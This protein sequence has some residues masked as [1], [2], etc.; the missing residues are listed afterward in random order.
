MRYLSGDGLGEW[1]SSNLMPTAALARL[2]MPDDWANLTRGART[3]R[4]HRA[5]A[6]ALIASRV[7]TV[8]AAGVVPPR[9]RLPVAGKEDARTQS[10]PD[11]TPK[12]GP[13]SRLSTR[14]AIRS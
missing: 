5:P 12:V 7:A 4:H 9:R 14:S 10:T 3:L 8:I 1:D 13:I 11:A 2:E 6:G